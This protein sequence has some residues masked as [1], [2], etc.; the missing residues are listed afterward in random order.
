MNKQ[1]PMA[2][3]TKIMTALVALDNFTDLDTPFKVDNR[4][5]GV[6][7][8]SIYLKKDEQLSMRE[9]LYGMML[10]SGNDASMAI[11]YKV[12][13]NDINKFVQMMN[14]KAN[15]LNLHNTH[16]D[17]PHGLDSPTHYT[18]AY[19]MAMITSK[20]MENETFREIVKTTKKQISSNTAGENRFLR[21][22]HK[23]VGNYDGCD[24]V[25][26][27]FTDN[28]RR[29]CVTS[30]KRDNMRLVCVVLN[31]NDMFEETA[32]LLDLAYEKYK[33]VQL[34]E[35]YKFLTSI[36]VENGENESVKVFT[37]KGFYYPL[38]Q[39]EMDFVRF[40][41]YLPETVEAPLEKHQQIG[42]YEIYLDN[43]LIFTE[44]I[45][46]IEDV[47][48]AGVTEKIKDILERWYYD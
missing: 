34:L 19:D 42:N 37:E 5:V 24:G 3:T 17:N 31:C 26:I 18:S 46:T 41:Q 32:K 45:Y 6:E 30:A 36:K 22:K 27:G 7:G 33:M 39:R 20:A 11:A 35:P 21:N 16:F 8:T 15:E 9:L 43:D 28:A 12:G 47:N 40:K 13:E 1:L 10:P 38:T 25:K 44:K 2:S 48:I 4:A 29:C 14:D 23:L